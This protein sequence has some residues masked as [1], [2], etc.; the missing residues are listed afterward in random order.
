[1][2]ATL[3]TC[4]VITDGTIGMETQ[5]VGL[6]EAMGLQPVIKRV[7]MR[8]LWRATSPYLNIGKNIAF[9]RKGDQMNA[10]WPDIVIASGRGSV[11]AS[12]Y[13]KQQSGGRSF[14]IQIQNPAMWLDKFDAI[15]VPEHDKMSGPN[16]ISTR[17]ALHRV[18][19]TKLQEEAAKWAP[20]FAHLKRPYAL[21]SLGGSNSIYKFTPVEVM[22]LA[23]QLEA[24]AKRDG[25]SLLI[26]PSRR[27]GEANMALLSAL[28]HD[29]P[30]YIWD[31]TGDNPYYGM[32]G[33]ADTI[34]VT[35]DS[36]NMVSEACSTG[37]PV[38]LIQLPGHSEKFGF[39]HDSLLA[40]QRIRIFNGKLHNWN[41]PRL[42]EMERIAQLMLA[43]YQAR[44]AA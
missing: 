4:W 15:I 25:Y 18:S 34:M 29:S 21:V 41:Y 12:L 24:I 17:G 3:P 14:N 20:K 22:Q 35:C 16:I 36:V 33:L 5:C 28:L 19:D 44:R 26:T 11:L 2:N 10:P 6:A 38:H 9:S 32:L 43:Q 40:D 7:R 31:G 27:T 37:K 23:P 42:L 30:A 1:M 39:F 13:V 8:K